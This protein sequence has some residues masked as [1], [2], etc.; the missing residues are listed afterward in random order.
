MKLFFNPAVCKSRYFTDK[1]LFLLAK[2]E[3]I[4][5]FTLIYV[6]VYTQGLGRKCIV[7]TSTDFVNAKVDLFRIFV[8]D[9][10]RET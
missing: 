5:V 10:N 3:E 4:Q 8:K 9:G 2:R 1:F 7:R 6:P